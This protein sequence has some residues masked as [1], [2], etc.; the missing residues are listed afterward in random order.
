[1][2]GLLVPVTMYQRSTLAQ[3]LGAATQESNAMAA[4]AL[5]VDDR[6][7]TTVPGVFAAGDTAALTPS[8]ANAI[9]SGHTAAAMVVQSLISA[10]KT[11]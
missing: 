7:Q 8:V 9:A 6:F 1:M 10:L 5:A 3:T 2:G 11:A 4:D